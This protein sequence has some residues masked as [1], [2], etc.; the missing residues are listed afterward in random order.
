MRLLLV[1]VCSLVAIGTVSAQPVF[2]FQPFSIPED[3]RI[4]V[5]VQEGENFTGL[6]KLIDEKTNGAVAIAAREAEFVG[7][8]QSTL[9]LLGAL[10]YSRIDLIGVGAESVGRVAAENFGGAAAQ[11]LASSKGGTIQILWPNQHLN[12]KK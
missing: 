6:A 4:V 10:P 12:G 9:T 8:A 3:G 2:E 11:L 5:P 1:F 7:E